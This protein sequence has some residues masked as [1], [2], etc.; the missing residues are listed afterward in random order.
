M[1]VTLPWYCFSISSPLYISI[2]QIKGAL[3]L[4]GTE[5]SC[6]TPTVIKHFFSFIKPKYNELRTWQIELWSLSNPCSS[7]NK[8]EL[9]TC[10]ARN[11]LNPSPNL[12]KPNFEPFWTL[13]K[14]NYKPTRW[15]WICI[16]RELIKMNHPHCW[17]ILFVEIIIAVRGDKLVHLP[18]SELQLQFSY[19]PIWPH[20]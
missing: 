15:W 6:K 7:T 20:W 9:R 11:G 19:L 12:E 14:L 4:Y 3:Y 10:L 13:L 17:F 18:A 8:P 16:P 1:F 2:V 5:L